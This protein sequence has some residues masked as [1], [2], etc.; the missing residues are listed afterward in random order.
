[1]P[2]FGTPS[3]M[4]QPAEKSVADLEK[5]IADLERESNDLDVER[6]NM[7]DHGS[8]HDAYFANANFSQDVNRKLNRAR[9]ELAKKKK[10]E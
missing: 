6:I 7:Q 2:E 5:E 8:T 9:E 1:M 3:T 10:I 4:L